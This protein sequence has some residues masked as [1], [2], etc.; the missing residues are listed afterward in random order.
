[1][2]ESYLAVA[3]RIRREVDQIEDVVDRAQAIWDDM[4]PDRPADYRIDTVALNLHGFYSS[5]V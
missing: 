2:K 4:N 3:G 5:R 1:M